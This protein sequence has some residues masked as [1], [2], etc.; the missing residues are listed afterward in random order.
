MLFQELLTQVQAAVALAVAHLLVLVV[1]AAQAL[2]LS[3][4]QRRKGINKWQKI[5][6]S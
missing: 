1:K 3:D 5:I 4:T 2:L 6:F